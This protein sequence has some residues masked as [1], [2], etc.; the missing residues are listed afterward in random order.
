MYTNPCIH[1]LFVSCV[2]KLDTFNIVHKENTL[3]KCVPYYHNSLSNKVRQHESNMAGY[4]LIWAIFSSIDL[5]VHCQVYVFQNLDE[6]E[7]RISVLESSI[8]NATSCCS[9]LTKENEFLKI[10]N[11]QL[12]SM[13]QNLSAQFSALQQNMVALTTVPT[14]T[15]TPSIPTTKLITTTATP[16][17]PG[18]YEREREREAGILFKLTLSLALAPPSP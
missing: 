14:T 11:K 3:I 16:T 15:P 5:L 4:V 17:P 1:P 7:Q 2:L 9:A 8:A 6:H 12:F 18:N 13:V 10:Q